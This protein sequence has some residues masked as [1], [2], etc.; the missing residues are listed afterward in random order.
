MKRPL[1]VSGAVRKKK[2]ADGIKSAK[3]ALRAKQGKGL[4]VDMQ[5]IIFSFM[6]VG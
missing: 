2:L 4:W 1:S 3:S 5:A 6:P